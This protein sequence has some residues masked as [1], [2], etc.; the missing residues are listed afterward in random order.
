MEDTQSV[1]LPSELSTAAATVLSVTTV[2]EYKGQ[3][4]E[5]STFDLPVLSQIKFDLVAYIDLN[6]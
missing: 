1:L 2:Q 5:F 6:W 4:C 3:K